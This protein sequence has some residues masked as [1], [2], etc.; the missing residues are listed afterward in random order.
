MAAIT[1]FGAAPGKYDAVRAESPSDWVNG[2]RREDSLLA[3]G[4]RSAPQAAPKLTVKL[5]HTYL[6][7]EDEYWVL[8]PTRQ[9]TRELAHAETAKEAAEAERSQG[10]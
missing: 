2:L 8:G 3:S 4:H 5:H 6:T 1:E 10:G 9:S 7:V